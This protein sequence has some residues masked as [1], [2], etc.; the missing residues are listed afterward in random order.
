MLLLILLL[1]SAGVWAQQTV[2]GTVTDETGAPMPGVSILVKGTINGTSTDGDGKYSIS[3]G[4]EGVLVV[5][6]IGYVTLEVNVSQRTVVDF[7]L[8]PDTKTLDEVIVTGYSQQSKRDVTGAVSTISSQTIAQQPVADVTSILQ[9]RVAGVTV[10][11]QGGPG[12]AQVVRVRGI[13]T[14]GGNDPLYVIDGVQTTGGINL[15]NQN[16]IET[17]TVLKDAASCALYGARGSNGVIVITTKRG[18]TGAPKIEY[19]GYVGSEVPRKSPDMLNPQQIADAYWGYLENSGLPFSSSLYGN[20]TTPVLPDYIVAGNSFSGGVAAGDPRA[21]P[22]LYNFE[23]YRIMKANKSG[24]NWFDEVLNPAFVQS[25][26]LAISGA[27]DKNNYAVTFNYLNNNGTLMNS[28]FKRYSIRVNTDFEATKWLRFGETMMFSYANQNTVNDHT[29]QNTIANLFGISPLMPVNDIGG[30][31]TGTKAAPVELQGSN[32]V[33]DRDNSKNAKGYTARVMGAAYVEVEPLEDLI[34]Q[35]KITIDFVPFQNR[36]FK[37]I[38]PQNQFDNGRNSFFEGGGHSLEWRSTNKVQYSRKIADIHKIDGFVA[39]EAS[40]Y[41]YRYAGGSNDSLFSLEPGFLVLGTGRPSTAKV[42]GSQD[43]VNYV[44]VF[45]NLNYS[46]LDRYLLGFTIRRDGSSKF[47]VLNRYG[48][49]PSMSAGWRI[50]Q[51]SF[52]SGSTAWLDDLK[53]RVSYG[54]SGN[55]ASIPTGAVYNQYGSQATYMYYDLNGSGNTSMQGFA[56][57]QIGN[58]YLQ[59][60]VNKTLNIGFDAMLFKSL[61]ASFNW[62]KRKTDKL[63]YQP[64]ATALQGDAFKP[65]QN[66][67]NFENKGIELELGYTGNQIEGLRYE[68]NFNIATYRNEVTYIDGDPTTFINGD[69]YARQ[70]IL[71]R[72]VVGM[73]V[74]SLYGYVYEGI[75]QTEEE[76]TGHATQ[77]GINQAAPETGLG[78]FKFKDLSGPDGEPDGIIDNYDKTFIG[79]PHPKFTY[80]FNVNLYYKNFDLGI[81]FQ[82]VHGNKIMNYWRTS[83][84]WPGRYGAGSLDTWTPENT[85][86]KLPIYSSN[87]ST[88]DAQ[89][90]SYF[91]E[92]GSYMRL[93]NLQIGYTFPALKGITKLRVYGQAYNLLTITKYSGMDPEVNTGAPGAIGID[94]GGN[95]PIAQKFLLGVNLGF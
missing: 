45:G 65:Y 22:S 37:D 80:G 56:L 92:D 16:D 8:Q 88:L 30:N 70:A 7:Q 69:A 21:D 75:F 5:S 73:P 53:L 29:D 79:N 36:Y 2:T 72:S 81:F 1:S 90:S 43:Q 10:D 38:Y 13:G 74:S 44:S 83:Y 68:V 50:S 25:H 47:G 26:Q 93:K 15:I 60:E 19:N 61:S 35:S 55:D 49:F 51:E 18:K 91:V 24:T 41:T 46:L 63:L 40:Q 89:A 4:P 42:N 67:M 52:M 59:W 12:N 34:V 82:G 32:A 54:T 14:L 9:G 87:L 39:F 84:E 48:V 64:P 86:A 17:I 76:V 28:Y 20:G 33:M 6:F 57:S 94:F 77:P 78:H 62:F 31:Y 58:P 3:A 95:Y 27:T 71:S 23:N 85:D 11:G 66:V